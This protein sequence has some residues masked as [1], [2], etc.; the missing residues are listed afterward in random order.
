M[1]TRWEI[2]MTLTTF[3]SPS[4]MVRFTVLRTE[5][6]ML[7]HR[8]AREMFL[9]TLEVIRKPTMHNGKTASS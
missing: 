5:F 8:V 4:S 7:T 6:S 1:K 9:E 2:Q 3:N